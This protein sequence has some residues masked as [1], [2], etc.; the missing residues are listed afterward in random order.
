[1]AVG[2]SQREKASAYNLKGAEQR[3]EGATEELDQLL[4][5][6]KA[7]DI[8]EETEEIVLKR[9]KYQVDYAQ[10]ALEAVKLNV[11]R[12]LEVMIPRENE[13]LK[14]A[15]RDQDLALQLSEITLPRT[16]AKKE[17]DFDK[18][19]RDQKKA[20]KKLDELKEDLASIKVTAPADG[21]VYYGTVENGKWTTG[22]VVAKKLI[23]GG[24][25]APQEVFMTLLDPEKL[26]IKSILN[27]GDLAN[28]KKGLKGKA[29]PAAA[30]DKKL[31]VEIEDISYFPLPGGGYEAKLSVNKSDASRLVPGMT[32]K[33]S[34]EDLPKNALVVP[35][36]AVVAEGQ[37]KVIYLAKADGSFE[38]KNV[39]TGDSDDKNIEILEGLSEGDS[40][41][42]KKPE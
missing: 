17:L 14:N 28:L 4:K 16:L 8:T 5:M 41:Y 3:L 7:D 38:K 6:Y 42:S 12:E 30:P 2:R 15:K 39:K 35:K 9:Q 19:K 1:V 31:D 37:Q 29:S 33:V 10:Y 34:F 13:N 24:K 11:K 27:E 22:G 36:D 26:V 20:A 21:V 32:C 23:Q 25:V 18:S 40:F